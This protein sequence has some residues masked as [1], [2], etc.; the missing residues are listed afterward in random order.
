MAS[1]AVGE[2]LLGAVVLAAAA[3]FLIYALQ[4]ADLGGSGYEVVAKFRKAEGL[5]VGADVRVA[6][7]KVG[8]VTDLSLDPETY[9]AVATLAVVDTVSIPDDSDAKIAVESL[10]GGSFIAITPGASEFMLTGGD[11]IELTQGSVSLLDLLL[12]FGTASTE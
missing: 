9:E 12:K 8:S 2:T 7:V 5:N 11:Q 3:G 1:R 4:Q 6:G 10:L